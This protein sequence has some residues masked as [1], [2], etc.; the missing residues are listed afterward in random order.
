ML[1]DTLVELFVT[2]TL[3]IPDDSKTN[4]NYIYA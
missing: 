3:R 2:F 4:A 1:N